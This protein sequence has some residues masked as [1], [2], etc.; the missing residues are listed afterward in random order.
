M[1]IRM[2][3]RIHIRFNIPCI[4]YFMCNI[5]LFQY[6]KIRNICT[7]LYLYGVDAT[8]Y[9]LFRQYFL[10]IYII[11]ILCRSVGIPLPIVDID[12]YYN[13]KPKLTF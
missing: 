6:R 1:Y 2:S 8:L 4:Y 9:T 5:L 11:F 13:I 12:I 10:N 7:F 3:E